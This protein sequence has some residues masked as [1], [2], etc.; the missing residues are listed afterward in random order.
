MRLQGE[1]SHW[2]A[3][4]Q[5]NWGSTS[6][7]C[8]YNCIQYHHNYIQWV[9]ILGDIGRFLQSVDAP[10]WIFCLE[11]HVK[12]VQQGNAES[13]VLKINPLRWQSWWKILPYFLTWALGFSSEDF[14]EVIK[15]YLTCVD[16]KSGDKVT[17]KINLEKP[18]HAGKGRFLTKSLLFGCL[19]PL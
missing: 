6:W 9:F 19:Q 4:K 8:T 10:E 16:Q 15:D 18:K 11:T 13:S 3:C 2:T 12:L 5:I 14:K 1:R 7:W 17:M